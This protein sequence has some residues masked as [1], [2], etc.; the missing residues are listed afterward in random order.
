MGVQ[1]MSNSNGGVSNPEAERGLLCAF[2]LDHALLGAHPL[3]A[4]HFYDTK[5]QAV[6]LALIHLRERGVTLASGDIVTLGEELAAL[7]TLDTVGDDY[8][9]ELTDEQATTA[10]AGEHARIVHEKAFLRGLVLQ[11]KAG[12][13]EIESGRGM[14]AALTRVEA[15]RAAVAA[16]S[17]TRG[18]QC[19]VNFVWASE[20]EMEPILWLW[21]GWLAKG[22][23]SLFAGE[24]GQGKS[25]ITMDIAARISAGRP[26]PGEA[27]LGHEPGNVL[28]LSAEDAASDIIVPRLTAAKADLERIA[29]IQ[30]V[31]RGEGRGMVSLLQDLPRVEETIKALG[32]VRLVVIDPITAYLGTGKVD[33]HNNTDVRAALAPVADMADRLGISVL[34]VT[35]FNKG[36]GSAINRI[37][38][39]IAFVAAC[40]IAFIVAPDQ[41][42]A[43]RVL[44]LPAKTNI[45]PKGMD[46][47]AYRID[48]T[49]VMA[50]T[51]EIG[52]LPLVAWETGGVNVTADEAVEVAE[53]RPRGPAPDT[54][55]AAEAWLT[56]VLKDGPVPKR[57]IDT[58]VHEQTTFSRCSVDRARTSL[59][60][61]SERRNVD[62]KSIQCW[63][64]PGCGPLLG[65]HPHHPEPAPEPWSIGGDGGFNGD[66]AAF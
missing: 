25:L 49:K 61:A 3:E 43:E 21:Q 65:G 15:I 23:L 17:W 59:G 57:V 28:I 9:D 14:D 12:I 29:I 10:L 45:G 41:D 53:R 22:K 18:C 46:G 42:D 39:S 6:Y 66:E 50:G 4:G 2:I 40:R 13:Q 27:G 56:T 33:S 60:I 5:N 44:V 52:T 35:H 38:G 34:A 7:G 32:H 16:G 54:R 51:R 37:I 19:K 63:I 48:T 1:A 8:L 62:G 58:L 31:D 20:V 64:L 36:S 26:F 30:S 47:L 11:H 24:P 55:R